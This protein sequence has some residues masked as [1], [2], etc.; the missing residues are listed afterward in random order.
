[1]LVALPRIIIIN[2]A[3]ERAS[4]FRNK[5]LII[6]LFTYQAL[7][8]HIYGISFTALCGINFLLEKKRMN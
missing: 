8:A 7:E 1:M 3:N 5:R 6:L 2:Y 4:R